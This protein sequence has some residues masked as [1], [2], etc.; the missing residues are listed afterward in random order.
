MIMWVEET[1]SG[2]FKF[3]ERYEDF[4][5]GKTKRVS[6]VLEKNTTQSRKTAQKTLDAKIDAALA[7]SA[8]KLSMRLCYLPAICFSCCSII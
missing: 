8:E 4:M 3:V 6:V 5:T 1:K 7:K 2:K